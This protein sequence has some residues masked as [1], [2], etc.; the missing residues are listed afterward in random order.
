MILGLF[1]HSANIFVK[2][3]KERKETRYPLFSWKFFLKKKRPN[4]LASS[5]L[6]RKSSQRPVHCTCCT[7]LVHLSNA[8][9]RLCGRSRDIYLKSIVNFNQKSRTQKPLRGH[10][11]GVTTNTTCFFSC[12]DVSSYIPCNIQCL[13]MFGNW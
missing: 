13:T 3:K 7:R 10:V 8:H 4:T 12:F 9:A 1:S 6:S 2:G 11:Q 5:I